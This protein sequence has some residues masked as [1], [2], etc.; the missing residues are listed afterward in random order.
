MCTLTSFMIHDSPGFIKIHVYSI[1]FN[2]RLSNNKPY[3]FIYLLLLSLWIQLIYDGLPKG[4]QCTIHKSG[5]QHRKFNSQFNSPMKPKP[6]STQYNPTKNK[7]QLID[8]VFNLAKVY[9]Y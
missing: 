3:L 7:I 9:W 2:H 1:R 5:E 6:D 8:D 4:I